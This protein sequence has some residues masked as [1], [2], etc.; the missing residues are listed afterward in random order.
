MKKY[1]NN[2]LFNLASHIHRAKF[3]APISVY[4]EDL[5]LKTIIGPSISPVYYNNPG[6]TVLDIERGDSKFNINEITY[7]FYD[8]AFY[9]MF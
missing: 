2:V 3:S 1:E 9:I 6:F 5:N 7:H 4:V 8:L